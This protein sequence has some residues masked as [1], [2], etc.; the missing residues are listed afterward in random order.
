MQKLCKLCK[1]CRKYAENMQKICRNYAHNKHTLYCRHNKLV[2]RCTAFAFPHVPSP[3][4]LPPL[5]PLLTCLPPLSPPSHLT[6]APSLPPIPSLRSGCSLVE[7]GTNVYR[8]GRW[9]RRRRSR[10]DGAV[11]HP[12]QPPA[13]LPR[14]RGLPVGSLAHRIGKITPPVLP[15]SGVWTI[16]WTRPIQVGPPCSF[17]LSQPIHVGPP[18]SWLCLF[19]FSF[20]FPPPPPPS[21]PQPP[22][23]RTHALPMAHCTTRTHVHAHTYTHTHTRTHTLASRRE[24]KLRSVPVHHVPS[25]TVD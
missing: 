3:P 1:L 8:H 14:G 13:A 20:P 2:L 16:S 4:T 6:L 21:P 10:R 7:M 17:L 22:P 24:A 23:H 9:K 18:C 12:V 11:A 15:P 5:P 19:S 25:R